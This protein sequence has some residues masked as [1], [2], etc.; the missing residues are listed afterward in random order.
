MARVTNKWRQNWH[1][2]YFF[3]FWQNDGKL[4]LTLKFWWQIFKNAPPNFRYLVAYIFYIEILV[5]VRWQ[6]NF[7]TKI[8]VT[9]FKNAP[10]NFRRLNFGGVYFLHQNFVAIQW[11]IVSHQNFSDKTITYFG[12]DTNWWPLGVT[13]FRWQN[14]GKFVTKNFGNKRLFFH[15]WG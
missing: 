12:V 15:K 3:K 7:D 10:P 13:I 4:I 14:S 1:H 5:S 11:K 8:S 9:N 2:Y 6:S